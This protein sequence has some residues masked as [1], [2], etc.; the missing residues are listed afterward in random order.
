[1]SAEE[2]RSFLEE[3]GEGQATRGKI[4]D[5]L[6]SYGPRIFLVSVT[7]NAL[8]LVVCILLSATL[9]R[10]SSMETGRGCTHSSESK[11]LAEPYCEQTPFPNDSGTIL[12]VMQRQQTPSSNMSIDRWLAM[13]LGS[14]AI[15]VVC[16]RNQ[17]II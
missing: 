4:V 6:G 15:L 2:K 9:L 7:C 5:R 1:M 8:L 12:N 16:G 13:T 3:A 17:C 10:I 14:L 11:G